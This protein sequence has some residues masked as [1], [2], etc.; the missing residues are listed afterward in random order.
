M[1]FSREI[2]RAFWLFFSARKREGRHKDRKRGDKN[3]EKMRWYADAVS[4]RAAVP[5]RR[6]RYAFGVS[7]SEM[8]F[9]LGDSFYLSGVLAPEKMSRNEKKPFFP[10]KRMAFTFV[11]IRLHV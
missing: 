6:G 5:C 4:D 7:D 3:A 9:Y 1:S 10:E 8:C 11:G 2:K